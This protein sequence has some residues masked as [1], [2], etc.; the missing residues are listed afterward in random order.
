MAK[1]QTLIVKR[2]VHASPAEVY[3]ALTSSTA[4]REW[5]SDV[6]VAEPRK[7]GRFYAAWNSGYFAAGEFIKASA[8]RKVKLTW[9]GRGEPAPTVV[10]ISLGEKEHGT[11]LKLEH[12][13]LGTGKAWAAAAEAL[14]DLW[15]SALENLQSVL[16]TGEDLRFTMRPMLGVTWLEEVN[17]E[18]AARLGVPAGQG[19]RLDGT[20]P[21]LGAAAAGLQHNDV[22][23]SLDGHKVSSFGNLVTALAGHRAGDTVSVKLLRGG[24]AQIVNMTLSKRPLPAIPPTAH[25]LSEAVAAVYNGQMAE[26]DQALSGVTEAE[27]EFHSAPGEWNIKEVL[28][29]LIHGERYT[30]QQ[31]GESLTGALGYYDVGGGNS[32]AWVRATASTYPNAGAMLQE[33]K[34]AQAE[35]VAFLAG[36]PE[37]FVAHKGSYWQ[38]AY[39]ALEGGFHIRDHIGQITATRAAASQSA[40]APE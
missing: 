40:A 11:R 18:V 15:R 28:A 19:L 3:R 32:D 4:L 37:P 35:T 29:H 13:D 27:S 36:L 31:L 25:E 16:E 6:A 10:K 34:R 33:L 1:T 22:V 21:G 7:G 38:I 39:G 30:Q 24:E 2:T 5:F 8:A 20:V 12:E 23:L 17:D 9:H 14:A 26:L